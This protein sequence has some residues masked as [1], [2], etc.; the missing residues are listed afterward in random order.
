MGKQDVA[1]YILPDGVHL[2]TEGNRVVAE[3]VRDVLVP[4]LIAADG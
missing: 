4:M 2:T 3:S 1:T